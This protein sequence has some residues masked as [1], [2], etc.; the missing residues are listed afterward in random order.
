MLNDRNIEVVT[1]VN[2]ED[3]VEKFLASKPGEYDCI[4]MDVMM[5]VMNGYEATK[6]IRAMEQRADAKTIPIIAM[7]ANAF[8]EDIKEALESGM[9]TH[10]SK[11][12]NDEKIDEALIRYVLKKSE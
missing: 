12:V 4:F 7:T 2:G 5:P 6:N 3:A 11:P 9:T 8:S 10:V 1:A